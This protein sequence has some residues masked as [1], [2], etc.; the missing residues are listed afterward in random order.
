V[1]F[2]LKITW[3]SPDWHESLIEGIGGPIAH[4]HCGVHSANLVLQDA[5]TRYPSFSWIK[6]ELRSLFNRLQ[7]SQVRVLLF[8][9]GYHG[10]TPVIQETK[11]MTFY[12]AVIFINQNLAQIVQV[13]PEF[14]ACDL[15]RGR[16]WKSFSDVIL[17]FSKF[18]LKVLADCTFDQISMRGTF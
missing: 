8:H 9:A 10:K 6:D 3:L 17:C 7:T 11:W 5:E 15:L 12:E 2:P 4:V 16:T 14:S 1:S 13:P 18:I